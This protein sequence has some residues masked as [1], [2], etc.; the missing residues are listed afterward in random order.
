MFDAERAQTDELLVELASFALK[1]RSFVYWAWAWGEPGELEKRPGPEPWQ[2]A[3]LD[4]LQ[5]K[6]LAGLLNP[7]HII[8]EAIQIAA[9]SGHDVGKSALVCWLI[10]WAISTREDTKGVVTANTEKQL[11][12]KLWA[13]LAKWHRLFIAKQF[14]KVT[15][16]SIQASDPEREKEWRIDAIP[17]SEDNPEAFAGLHNLGKRIIVIFDEASGITEKI[18]E[19][20]DGVMNEAGTELIWIATGNPTRNIG[21]FRE[22]FDTQGQGQ[23]WK[24]FTVD[25]RAVSFT[26]KER[27]QKAIDLWGL[28][29]DYIKVRWL[30]EFPSAAAN[31]LIPADDIKLAMNREVQSLYGESLIMGVDVARYGDNESVIAFRRG[32]DART[33]KAIRFRGLNNVELADQIAAQ[34]AIHNPDAIFIDGG[35]VGGGVID[36][37]RRLGHSPIEVQFGSAAG[38][39]LGGEIAANKR[40]EIYLSLRTWLREG[41]CLENSTE[42][43]KQIVAQ[44]YT[45]SKAKHM[46]DAIVLTPK[47][48]MDESPDW[49][50]AI[51]LTFSFPVSAVAFHGKANIKRDYDPLAASALPGQ[52]AIPANKGMSDMDLYV[53]TLRSIH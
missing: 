3:L 40:A 14:F 32:K 26:N 5:I 52:D 20:I 2:D 50:D 48:E 27:I 28:D 39:P 53:Q 16:T 1:P 15:A 31:Q 33:I 9:K 13:E 6:L 35:G 19:T 46:K 22:C 44:E 10:I 51:A 36:F 38:I 42:L 45:H 17:W 41:G 47:E 18:W 7:D 25:S 34:K 4:Y 8:S 24:T 49:S 37:L 30:G 12:L 23:F 43:Y 11:R 29:N 21:R